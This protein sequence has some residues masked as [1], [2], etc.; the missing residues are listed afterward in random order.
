M[1]GQVRNSANTFDRTL[2]IKALKFSVNMLKSC[3]KNRFLQFI[4]V[5]V[6]SCG[7]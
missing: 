1:L 2:S 6:V 7:L 4:R 3:L 5:F